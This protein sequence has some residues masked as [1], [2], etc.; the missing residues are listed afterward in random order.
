MCHCMREAA[1][2][3]EEI[4]KVI[5]EKINPMLKMHNGSCQAVELNGGTLAVKLNGG[6]AGC[7]SSILTL[8]QLIRPVLIENCTGVNDV[9]IS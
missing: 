5:D 3:M 8:Y 7:P 1:K 2:K 4:Q 9:V 6:C